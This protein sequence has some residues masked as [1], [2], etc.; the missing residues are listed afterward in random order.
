MKS[1][2]GQLMSCGIIG[3]FGDNMKRKKIEITAK[4]ASA[5]INGA[6]PSPALESQ[7]RK[8]VFDSN[9]RFSKPIKKKS[10]KQV[11][12]KQ[13]PILVDII[14]SERGWGQKIDS[15]K[16]FPNMAKAEAFCKE[17]NKHNDKDVVPDWY[18]VAR[19]RGQY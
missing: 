16:K 8:I 11:V 18:M 13:P 7:L 3:K 19:I 12:K 4:D 6:K 14:E 17:F 2:L 5:I 10:N 15:T 9:K 1:P